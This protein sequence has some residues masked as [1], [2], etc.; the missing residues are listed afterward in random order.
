MTTYKLFY[1]KDYE[2]NF[3]DELKS[4]IQKYNDKD[5]VIKI[6][7]IEDIKKEWNIIKNLRKYIKSGLPKYL[8]SPKKYDNKMILILPFY[9]YNSIKKAVWGID[10]IDILKSLINQVFINIF[11]SFHYFGLVYKINDN[12]LNKILINE[13]DE[14]IFKYNYQSPY[15]KSKRTFI[16]ETQGYQAVI[17][18]LENSYYVYKKNGIDDYWRNIYNFIESINT[19]L[20]IKINN[21]NAIVNFIERQLE[22]GGDY[23]NS[24]KLHLLLS[25]SKLSIN[26]NI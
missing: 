14:P 8:D 22:I 24:I 23:D 20:M 15:E 17:T 4:L 26:C 5:L 19:V 25:S 21:Y 12:F 7:E 16:I 1:L 9:Q 18:D 10:N 3:D 2:Y 6:G 13:I 11:L